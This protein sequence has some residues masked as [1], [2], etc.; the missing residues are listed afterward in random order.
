MFKDLKN[1]MWKNC[2]EVTGSR[3]EEIFARMIKN[4]RQDTYKNKKENS[5][6]E[7][8]QVR[9]RCCLNENRNVDEK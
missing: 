4:K 7:E 2:F 8:I 9:R 6:F 1:V 3:Y 5:R